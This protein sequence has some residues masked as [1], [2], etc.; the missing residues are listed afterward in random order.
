M[1]ATPTDDFSKLLGKLGTLINIPPKSMLTRENGWKNHGQLMVIKAYCHLQSI[2]L[3]AESTAGEKSSQISHIDHGSIAVIARAA[4]ETF[5]LFNFIFLEEDPE[6]RQFRHQVWRLSGLMS[7]M[8]LNRVPGLP[9]ERLEQIKIETNEIARLQ[10]IIEGSRYFTMLSKQAKKNV[11]QGDGVRLGAA[12]IDLAEQ[13]GLP[14]KYVAD[15]YTHFCNSSHANAISAFQLSE[16]L[17]DGTSP[18]VAR[19]MIGFCCIL[20]TQMIFA[21]A[22]FFDEVQDYVVTDTEL[23]DLLTVWAT[24]GEAFSA[25]YED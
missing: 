1:T 2:A 17:K 10:P 7:R 5:V 24:L 16:T 6:L 13:A 4:Y 22:K 23:V 21:Y 8:K 12:L 25:M 3:L 9:S 20:L 18:I 14:R 19:G 15:M 11:R